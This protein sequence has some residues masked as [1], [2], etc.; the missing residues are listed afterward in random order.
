M[1]PLFLVGYM[2][3]GKTTLGRALAETFGLSF[4]DTDKY[5]E[6]NCQQSISSIFEYLGENAF[7]K[8]EQACLHE[9]APFDN[10]LVSTGGGMPC[11]ADNMD[12]MNSMGY[13]IY[14]QLSPETLLQRLLQEKQSRP[15]IRH[16]NADDLAARVQR[17]LALRE[18]YYL[19]AQCVF[20]TDGLCQ[21]EALM[22]L[23]KQLSL[24]PGLSI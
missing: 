23:Q 21:E 24:S 19:K 8:M 20:P 4:Y 16:L 22:Q 1:R 17:E 14:L 5:I 10:T 12:Y 15:L 9:L 6:T 7:R 18:P 3:A 13:T 2:C 11:Y